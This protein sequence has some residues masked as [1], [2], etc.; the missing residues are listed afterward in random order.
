MWRAKEAI[1]SLSLYICPKL[2]LPR[3][4]DSRL[5][6]RLCQENANPLEIETV[7]AGC[8]LAKPVF[9]CSALLC[10]RPTEHGAALH[11]YNCSRNNYGPSLWNQV[12]VVWINCLLQT[13]TYLFV[14]LTVNLKENA[15]NP[16]TDRVHG[17]VGLTERAAACFSCTVQALLSHAAACFSPSVLCCRA[18]LDVDVACT[19]PHR[20]Q[21]LSLVVLLL[22]VDTRP[23][24]LLFL[25]STLYHLL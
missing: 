6:D 9:P 22:Q 12:Y 25:L 19:G 1:F 5:G 18:T 8:K 13:C 23:H 10:C 20:S 7:E 2:H 16:A 21:S 11:P 15:W 17:S 4:G 14:V 24:V 3:K